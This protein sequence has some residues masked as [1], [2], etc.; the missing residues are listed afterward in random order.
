MK[1]K[2]RGGVNRKSRYSLGQLWWMKNFFPR[3]HYVFLIFSLRIRKCSRRRW[4]VLNFGLS[5]G[6][7][8]I[9]TPRNR[10]LEAMPFVYSWTLE[11]PK[12]R[13]SME[14]NF[15]NLKPYELSLITQY[16]H[17]RSAFNWIVRKFRQRPFKTVFECQLQN[18]VIVR[19]GWT[20]RTR[21]LI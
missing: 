16:F 6:I 19:K 12:N 20:T 3:L 4:E 8:F 15:S 7:Q 1:W 11:S 18:S 2:V 14:P 9:F 17:S 13:Q 21:W 5:F 10:H